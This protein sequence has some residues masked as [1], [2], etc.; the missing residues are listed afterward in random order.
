MKTH[1]PLFLAF[2][3]LAS[4]KSDKPASTTAPPPPPPPPVGAAPGAGCAQLPEVRLYLFAWNA[5]AGLL[6]ATGGKQA[7][8][9]SAMCKHGVNLRLLR[10]DNTDTM[11][12]LMVAF[13]EELKGGAA[14][15]AKG[16][17]FIAV[18]GDGSAAILKGLNDKLKKIGPD[19]TAAVIGS[20]GY[21]R[22]ED[23][24][25]GPP[26]WKQNPQAARGGLVAGVLRD[27]DWNIAM[28]WLGDH[29]IANNPDDTSY[30]PDALNWVNAQDY[31]E[32]AQKYV[33]G[34]CA[35]L[36][37]VKTG[38]REKR[39]VNGVVTWTPG[40][41]TVAEQKG[42]LASIVSTREYRTQMPQVII[43]NRRWMAQNRKLVTGLLTAAFEGAGQ[44]KQSEPALRQ[45]AAVSALVYGEKD[46]AYWAKYFHPQSEKDKQGLTVDLGGS[47]V[48]DLGDNIELFGLKPGT[49]NLF[50]AVYTVFANMVKS[51][52]PELLPQYEPASEV[53]DLS[54]LQELAS[55]K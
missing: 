48:S 52:Y 46:A 14:N 51:Q 22:G 2:L 37:N 21:S 31:I 44:L 12:S 3:G 32:A 19:Y 33:S 39:C 7:T 41:V 16:A 20:T 26:T 15:P 18:M 42:G 53:V 34:Y 38:N 49:Q 55:A 11:Q 23:K 28:K 45:A 43:G 29:K 1:R 35:E 5:Q 27:G 8:Q 30:D 24:F 9:D 25:M 40:D 13:A 50:A 10:E 54:Y 17:H 47:A 6:L 36:K 4:C